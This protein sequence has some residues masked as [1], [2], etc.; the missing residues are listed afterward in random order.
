MIYREFDKVVEQYLTEDDI[1]APGGAPPS[2]PAPG[3]GMGGDMGGDMGGMGGAPG[4]GAPAEPKPTGEICDL[5]YTFYVSILVEIYNLK[6]G[7]DK[8]RRKV[9]TMEKYIGG[10]DDIDTIQ[11]ANDMISLIKHYFISSLKWKNIKEEVKKMKPEFKIKLAESK[12]NKA[13]SVVQPDDQFKID[14]ARL[15]YAI[16]GFNSKSKQVTL[17]GKNEIN[18]GVSQGMRVTFDNAKTVFDD[19]KEKIDA[20]EVETGDVSEGE[21]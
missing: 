1:G 13:I 19:I 9:L 18:Y 21:R 5:K 17:P 3:G 2:P 10:L 4:G 14:L 20:K 15:L 7:G 8:F 12:K 16:I 11:K 6:L